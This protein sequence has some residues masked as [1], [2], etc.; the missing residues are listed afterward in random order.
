MACQAGFRQF[1]G[2]KPESFNKDLPKATKDF[3]K[4]TQAQKKQSASPQTSTALS[5]FLLTKIP[6][7]ADS[8]IPGT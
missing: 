3:S 4:T 6:L 2:E 8:F 7:I 1:S 5:T